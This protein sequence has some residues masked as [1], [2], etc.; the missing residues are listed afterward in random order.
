[1]KILLGGCQNVLSADN[2][3]LLCLLICKNVNFGC[4]N[5]IVIAVMEGGG[6]LVSVTKYM[7]TEKKD[8]ISVKWLYRGWL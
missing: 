4:L 2:S 6:V 3:P 5:K 8:V 7:G 1:V